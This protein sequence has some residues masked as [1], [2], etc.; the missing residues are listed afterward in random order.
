MNTHIYIYIGYICFVYGLRL[1]MLYLD[2]NICS[3]VNYSE[4]LIMKCYPL[5]Y[6]Y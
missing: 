5:S 1:L 2:M 3:D 6:I 4:Y